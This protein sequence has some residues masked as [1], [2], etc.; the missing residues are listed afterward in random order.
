[1]SNNQRA[2]SDEQ[3]AYYCDAAIDLMGRGSGIA[4]VVRNAAGQIVDAASRCLEGMTNNEAEYEA[5][6]L[7]LELA[8]ARADRQ[9]TFMVDSQIVVGQIAGCFAVRDHKLAPRHERAARLLAQLPEA[10]LVFVHRERNQLA[11]A[12]AAEAME[13]GLKAEGGRQTAEAGITDRTWQPGV[14]N[15]IPVQRMIADR[16]PQA[17]NRQL[18][19]VPFRSAPRVDEQ[20]A[21]GSLFEAVCDGYNLQRAWMEVRDGRTVADR[22]KGAGVDGVTVAEWDADC[23]ARLRALQ[24]NLQ[25]GVYQPSPLLWFDIPHREPG[26]TRRLG[27]PTVTDRVAQR[28]VKNVLEPIWED[29]F[30]S[31]SHGFRPNRSVFT[32]VAHVLWHQARGLC[33]VADADIQACFDMIEHNR[34]L[35][36][37]ET[38]GDARVANLIAGWLEAGAAAPGRGVAQGAVISPLMANIYLH[39]FDVAIV[40]AGLALVRYADDLVVMCASQQ[41]AAQALQHV[42]SALA[43]LGL[44]LNR[45]KTRI[46]QFGPEFTFL[47]A[48]FDM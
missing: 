10:T 35:A 11:D 7:G 21:T 44:S 36:E 19:N 27:I 41:D 45:D 48:Q 1:M 16:Q 37:V 47:G 34:L 33:W 31:C 5:L 8:M 13:A 15:D 17:A 25:R 38:M 4:V 26:R 32:A 20:R 39:P 28:A 43:N 9:V 23:Q 24:A 3:R 18:T 40:Q 12:L 14:A 2:T 46:V 30:L 22:H 29:V 6:I 42:A